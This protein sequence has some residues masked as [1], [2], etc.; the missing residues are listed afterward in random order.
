M[1]PPSGEIYFFLYLSNNMQVFFWRGI[2][3]L[4]FIWQPRFGLQWTRLLICFLPHRQAG[5][6][7]VIWNMKTA[8]NFPKNKN[9][10]AWKDSSPNG[11]WTADLWSYKQRL[12]PLDHT[13]PMVIIVCNSDSQPVF[14]HL[15]YSPKVF[16][17]TIWWLVNYFT[18]NWTLKVPL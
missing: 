3:G 1:F 5:K 12:L 15:K 18:F 10:K 16:F 11:I 13:T 4:L 2:Q 6:V 17:P 9:Q 7:S 14:S 8:L